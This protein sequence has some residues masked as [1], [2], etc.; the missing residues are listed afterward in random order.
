MVTHYPN[1]LQRICAEGFVK[2]TMEIVVNH[3]EYEE[4]LV[5]CIIRYFLFSCLIHARPQMKEVEKELGVDFFSSV[6]AGIGENWESRNEQMQDIVRSLF[7][8]N[9]TSSFCYIDCRHPAFVL[10]VFLY[11]SQLQEFG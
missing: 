5:F 2:R 1:F 9:Y 10:V 11:H 4:D 8:Y 3:M 6:L 7:L